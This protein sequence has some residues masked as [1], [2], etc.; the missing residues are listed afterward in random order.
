MAD[1][2]FILVIIVFFALCAASVSACD[3]IIRS[4]DDEQSAPEVVA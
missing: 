3:R 1:V 2:A 4:E